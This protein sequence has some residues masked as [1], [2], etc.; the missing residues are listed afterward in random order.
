[1]PPSRNKLVT[2]I[3]LY[4]SNI[5]ADLFNLRIYCHKLG[6]L[7]LKKIFLKVHNTEI[8]AILND[9]IAVQDFYSRLPLKVNFSNSGLDYCCEINKAIYN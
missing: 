3:N 8:Q 6:K 2:K 1:M 7:G 4:K 9:T 5:C